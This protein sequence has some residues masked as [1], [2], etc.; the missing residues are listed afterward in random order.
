MDNYGTRIRGFIC[1][2]VTG[3]YTFWISSDDNGE[4]WLSSDSDPANKTMIAEVPDWSSSREWDKF[5]EQQSNQI[6]LTAGNI[7]YIEAIAKEALGGDNLAVGWQLPGG[8]LERPMPGNRLSPFNGGVGNQLINF[9]EIADKLTTDAPFN[10]SA[11]A[12][13]GLPVSLTLVSGP[14]LVIGNQITLTG[15]PGTV[16]IRAS[17]GGDANWNS[18]PTVE[19]SFEVNN[20][21]NIFV[22]F[23][24]ET[25]LLNSPNNFNSGVAMGIA[26]MNGDGLDD[27]IRLDNARNL[28][29]EYQT[30]PNNAFSHFNFGNVSNQNEW[31]LVIADADE[32]GFNDIVTGGAYDNIK[33]L[34]ANGSGTNYTQS[35]LP[36]SNI[37]IQGSNFVDINND[38]AVDIF[39]CHDDAESRAYENDGSG[40][41]TFNENLI[42]TETVPASDNSGNYA[43]IWTDYDND[44][45]LD[46]YISKC[47]AGVG[48]PTDP[49][50]INM[51]WQNDGSNN[52]TEVAQGAGL[53]IGA[54]SWVTDFADIDN[55]GDLDAF[56][57]NHDI[58]SQ[59]M[60]NNGNGTFTDITAASGLT[61]EINLAGIQSFFKDFDNDGFVDLVISGTAQRMFKNNGNKTFTRIANPFNNNAMESMAIGDLNHDGFVDIY[62]GYANLYNSPSNIDDRLFMNAGNSNNWFAVNCVGTVS[63][64]NGI[65]ARIELH[66]SWGMQIREVRSGEGYGVMNSFTRFFG[67]GTANSI[68]KVVVKWPSG[69]I[70]EIQNPSINQFLTIT[71]S[72]PIEPTVTITSPTQNQVISGSTVTVNYQTAGDFPFYNAD[73]LE[74]YLDGNSVG[75]ETVLDGIFTINNVAVGNHTLLIE[76]VEANGTPLG[77]TGASD[78]VNFETEAIGGNDIDLELSMVASPS[79][80]S[81]WSN[82]TVTATITNNGVNAATGVVL[83]FPKPDEVVFQG[84]NASTV[85]QGSFDPF[86]TYDWNVGTLAAGNSATIDLNFFLL[87]ADPFFAYGQVTAA[88]GN[89]PDSSPNN[90]ACCAANEDDEFALPI[91]DVGPQNQTI[92]FPIIPNKESDDVPFNI[93]ATASSGL[94]VSFQIV[95][96]PATISGNT[97]TLTGTTGLVTVRASQGGNAQWNPAPDVERIFNVTDPGLQDQS[98]AFSNI[99]N[100]ITTDPAFMLNATA[101]S[102]LPVSFQIVSGP[103]TISG[104]ILT[105][106]GTSG[107]VTVRASQAGNA[108]YNPAPDVDRTFTVSNPAGQDDIDLELTMATSNQEPTAFSTFTI[109]A[110]IT[111]NSLNEATNV[112]VQFVKPSNTV[113]TGGNEFQVSQGSFTPFGNTL[114]NVGTLAAGASATLDANLFYLDS[115]P[116]TSYSQVTAATEADADSTPNNGTCCVG[117]EDDEIGLTVPQTGPQNQTITF[118]YIGDKESDE[119]PFTISATA[120]STLPVTFAIVS[121]PATISGN[122]ITLTGALGTV[123]VSA[124]QAGDANWNP[125]PEVTQSFNVTQP[126]L[127]NQTITLDPIPN[128]ITTDP[129][130][131]LPRRRVQDYPSP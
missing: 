12:S 97:I 60:E 90:G 7:Y 75:S 59:L 114:W 86:I 33:I 49:R 15:T 117:T 61:P 80:P 38:G 68:D 66:G 127:M 103:A 10:I 130:S 46:L 78:Q 122:I 120:T 40:N 98:I 74:F 101:S 77:N 124:N 118:P 111:N 125:A 69:I 110:T 102:G 35:N 17:Q 119:P 24:D 54:Q 19:Q 104:A 63:N 85:S 13:S 37:F 50:R 128:K 26:D 42:S 48:S 81:Q 4:L 106:D 96:G 56:I 31:S 34:K 108:T 82:F 22:N 62:A 64:V 105:L 84:G 116:A 123:E 79:D 89:D 18:A 99:P 109:T 47:R 112:V 5:P 30:T 20:P 25:N 73:R 16:I 83:N 126:G 3:N 57:V 107:M 21:P 93:S 70:N 28:N 43:S 53:K 2:P 52:F 29:I 51:L 27:I 72:A 76:I 91:P 129:L 8:T 11:S 45:D 32:N 39:A 65:G 1:P 36:N 92:T 115:D 113:F 55:D 87:S 67:I 131:R 95:S 71:E 88:I 94:P 23:S 44:G 100:K 121:G 9:P 14:A 58:L 6:A 41:F